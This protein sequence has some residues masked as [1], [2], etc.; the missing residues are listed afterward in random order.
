MCP[1]LR[2]KKCRHQLILD[3]MQK[4]D[5]IKRLIDIKM[6]EKDIETAHIKADDAILYFINDLDIKSAYDDI[7]KWYA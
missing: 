1:E 5:L 3:N 6:N 2:S 4:E 7:Q